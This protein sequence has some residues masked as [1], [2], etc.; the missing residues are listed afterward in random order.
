MGEE[1]GTHAILEL[2]G[3]KLKKRRKKE[4]RKK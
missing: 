4:R 3:S 1:V 2:K